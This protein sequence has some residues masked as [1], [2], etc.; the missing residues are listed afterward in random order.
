MGKGDK[1]TRRGKI[2]LGTF[3][4]RRRR[5]KSGHTDLKL[6][7]VAEEKSLK[8]KKPVKEQAEVKDVK[9]SSEVKPAKVVKAKVAQ[10]TPKALKE[11]KEIVDNTAVPKTKKE[12]KS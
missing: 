9:A 10:K 7:N 1:K 8:E 12:K 11:K 5:K 3:G 6:L 2:I 4:A